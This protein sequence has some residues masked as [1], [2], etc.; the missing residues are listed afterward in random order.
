MK[1]ILL[2]F[3]EE[4]FKELKKLKGKMTWK[5]FIIRDNKI[6]DNRNEEQREGIPL[7]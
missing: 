1:T 3:E 5:E 7:Q 4:E 2:Y 6:G